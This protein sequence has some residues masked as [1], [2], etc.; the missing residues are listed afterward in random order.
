MGQRVLKAHD[1]SLVQVR[2]KEGPR[3]LCSSPP[4]FGE[5]WASKRGV[6]PSRG[7]C[8][9]SV[10]SMKR[11]LPRREI[12]PRERATGSR[13]SCP[14]AKATEGVKSVDEQPRG[15]RRRRGRGTMRQPSWEQKRPVSA[16]GVEPSGAARGR[17][18]GAT[19]SISSDP[20]KRGRA[21]RGSERPI[22]PLMPWTTE[23]RWREG[24]VLGRC[25][26]WR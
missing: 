6:E 8:K 17:V 1:D 11:S 24:A 2:P 22:V 15:T 7:G 21:E 13:A 26:G 5:I 3:H 4:A 20:A 18:L 14:W 16:P 25:A 9:S 23:P 12:F 10:R 19:T